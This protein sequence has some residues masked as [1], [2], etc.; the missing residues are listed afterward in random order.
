MTRKDFK[1]IV[2]QLIVCQE[3][4][5]YFWLEIFS[6]DNTG[7]FDFAFGLMLFIITLPFFLWKIL[8][9]P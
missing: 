5:D 4:G 6:Q 7:G 9:E 2:D 8:N 1:L 3:H